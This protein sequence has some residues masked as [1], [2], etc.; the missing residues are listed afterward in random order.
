MGHCGEK[1]CTVTNLSLRSYC[2]THPYFITYYLSV[3]ASRWLLFQPV[4]KVWLASDS[5]THDAIYA[6][7]N[8]EGIYEE[9]CA[10]LE[11]KGGLEIFEDDN[12]AEYLSDA[13]LDEACESTSPGFNAHENAVKSLK[14]ENLAR[15][16]RSQNFDSI[17]SEMVGKLQ[18][19]VS[20][21]VALRNEIIQREE[22]R[23]T[24]NSYMM[25]LS[26][27]LEEDL[28]AYLGRCEREATKSVSAAMKDLQAREVQPSTSLDNDRL[29]NNTEL[30]SIS[31]IP[32]LFEFSRDKPFLHGPDRLSLEEKALA[33][34]SLETSS[35]AELEQLKAFKTRAV[36][37]IKSFNSWNYSKL[38]KWCKHN[39]K[40]SVEDIHGSVM[41]LFPILHGPV[42]LIGQ[43]QLKQVQLPK[44]AKSTRNSNRKSRRATTIGD[45]SSSNF[46]YMKKS[47]V[48]EAQRKISEIA[49]KKSDVLYGPVA[50][51]SQISLSDRETRINLQ[52][53]SR[54]VN[55]LGRD[56]MKEDDDT[57]LETEESN[58][59][60][61]QEPTNSEPHQ[62]RRHTSLN[63][64]G[65]S[66]DQ[67]HHFR[68]GGKCFLY[69]TLLN[70]S[71]HSA[72][73]AR[74]VLRTLQS[75]SAATAADSVSQI[76]TVLTKALA[77]SSAG[78]GAN[79]SSERMSS[80]D[81]SSNR[82]I[83]ALED[84]S[85]EEHKKIFTS[86]CDANFLK[87]RGAVE[88]WIGQNVG[89][90]YETFKGALLDLLS[91]KQL[92]FATEGSPLDAAAAEQQ[93][94]MFDHQSSMKNQEGQLLSSDGFNSKVDKLSSLNSNPGR[95]TA[96]DNEADLSRRILSTIENN[97]NAFV[98][99]NNDLF[100]E[101]EDRYPAETMDTTSLH[102]SDVDFRIVPSVAG[103]VTARKSTDSEAKSRKASTAEHVSKL[104]HG[105]SML[106]H[107]ASYHIS[108]NSKKLH[109]MELALKGKLF[110]ADF[111]WEQ[112]HVQLGIVMRHYTN[113]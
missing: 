99:N 56:S 77:E 98:S 92:D 65:Q 39:K 48:E 62:Y 97:I 21:C 18:R 4:L 2:I 110:T 9:L 16:L 30:N 57:S 109:S 87:A 8:F 15:F 52:H 24:M 5:H 6:A 58:A 88:S 40:G 104:V 71:A 72:L 19:V 51:T 49:S 53:S 13:I 69:V 59:R 31:I 76:S 67:S 96:A 37:H 82:T 89:N 12:Y 41:K 50:K 112:D 26:H 17:H 108:S 47:M 85:T 74:Q 80:V 23:S 22:L 35:A 105:D 70:L 107:R 75:V 103:S 60:L 29:A 79:K 102:R 113:K 25:E 32:K 34:H 83:D 95:V 91:S 94:A 46:D 78:S 1:E 55:E 64:Y 14:Q 28:E 100:G 90:G 73:S 42:E 84:I 61:E 43:G 33:E 86:T 3:S 44:E 106:S 111:I 38:Y 36:A 10:H 7:A 27:A 81:G 93:G 45:S 68:K 66:A 63:A 20:S 54:V 11:A 101:D